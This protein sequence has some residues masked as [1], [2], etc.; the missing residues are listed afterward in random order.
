MKN[1]KKV[2]VFD[3]TLRD[4]E[5]TPSISITPSN[6]LEIAM[7][8]DKLGVNIIEA[9]SPITSKGERE[10]IKQIIN[11]KLNAEICSF[12]RAL[13]LDIDKA[14]ECNVDS[15]HI[16]IPTSEIH[17]KYKMKK[18]KEEIVESALNSIEYA[19]E[20]GLI[21]ELSAEDATR[22][23]SDFLI[24]LF[25]TA[26]EYKIDRACICD[27]VGIL[28]PDKSSLLVKK[29]V[30]NIKTPLSIHCHNDFG[31]A[32]ANTVAGI[33]AGAKECHVTVN[34]L[35]ER[36]GNAPIDEVVMTLDKLYGIKSDINHSQL[37]KTSRLISK[38]V[39][40]PI[41]ANKSIVGENAFSHEAG[42]HVDGLI[43]NTS[44]YE[45]ILPEEVGNN[46]KIILGKHS[47]KS[48]LKYK[49]SLMNIGL[50]NKEF[51]Q[52][53]D[54]VKAYG[55]LGKYISDIDLKTIISEIKGVNIA[56]KV[57]LD[58]LTVISGNKITP[59]ASINLKFAEDY[60]PNGTFKVDNPINIGKSTDVRKKGDDR[61]I[62]KEIKLDNI[63]EAAYGV[64]P[65]DAAI[66]AVRKALTGVADIELEDYTVKAVSSGTDALIEV[67]VNLRRGNEVVQVKK[68][69]SDIIEASVEALMDGINLLL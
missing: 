27:T 7:E 32:T 55:D 24:E 37:S 11:Q 56:K 60:N 34:G 45:P 26:E 22:S 67:I 62:S 4:G 49:L 36:A 47:G 19:K 20:H 5:Q 17:M 2:V 35:G 10:A 66:N 68:A 59:L 40:V 69:H 31:M 63:R 8:L 53:Y 28:T 21:V 6:K 57:Y 3:T 30:E 51:N 12:V 64:G 1:S 50:N 38:L 54:K 15:V 25:K 46:R 44:T 65:V 29:I 23:E 33:N 39:K 42:I 43:K 41:P 58:E 14:L 52:V 18:S 9:G 13:P 61:K 48:A 16:V